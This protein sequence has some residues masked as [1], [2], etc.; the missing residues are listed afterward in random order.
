MRHLAYFLKKTAENLWSDRLKAIF[1]LLSLSC[2]L[3]LFGLFLLFY[4]NVNDLLHTLREEVHFS[5]YLR[6]TAGEGP[7]SDG[8]RQI[9]AALASDE[10]I[11]SFDYI[12]KQEAL[13]WFKKAY[14][15]DALLTG[16]GENPFP[17]SF[18]VKV[19]ASDQSPPKFRRIADQYKKM[20]GVEE[21]HYAAEWL[22]GLDGFLRFSGR[23]GWGIGCLLAVAVVTI[24][25][26]AVQLHFHSRAE[27]VEIMRLMGAT[28]PFIIIP[29]LLEGS[30]IGLLSGGFSLLSLFVMVQLSNTAL[31]SIPLGGSPIAL[32][33]FPPSLFLGFV[34]AGSGLGGLGSFI[35]LRRHAS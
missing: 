3:I 12:S 28:H 20:S 30:L 7:E 19:R 11:A 14:R 17:A 23:I 25:A 32:R 9:K 24:V 26:N 6:D 5:I 10:R 4:Y 34:L 29:F 1:L 2:P 33:F 18:E 21:V 15:D 13:Q 8:V 16:L 31:A 27:E 22:Q 35:S